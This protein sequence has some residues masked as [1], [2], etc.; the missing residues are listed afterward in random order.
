MAKTNVIKKVRT[1]SRA[2]VCVY[3]FF[4]L[5]LFF[6]VY[7]SV[8][9]THFV[10]LFIWLWALDT[11][12]I[13]VGNKNLHPMLKKTICAFCFYIRHNTRSLCVHS[14][15]ISVFVSLCPIFMIYQCLVDLHLLFIHLFHFLHILRLSLLLDSLCVYFVFSFVCFSLSTVVSSYFSG[16]DGVKA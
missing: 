9:N 8:L 7:V 11:W 13:S 5:L 4:A 14:P 15:C 12:Q 3:V 10:V 6:V 1:S 16:S 2:C